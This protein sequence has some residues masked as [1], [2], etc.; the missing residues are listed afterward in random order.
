VFI[1]AF[2]SI[3]TIFGTKY[4]ILSQRFNLCVFR[5]LSEFQCAFV[6][7][8]E[9]DCMKREELLGCDKQHG[10]KNKT[11][12]LY[13]IDIQMLYTEVLQLNWRKSNKTTVI[14]CVKISKWIRVLHASL[15]SFCK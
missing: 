5:D 7:G 6:R 13:L 15:N 1:V 10:V 2:Y 4:D 3:F 11:E 9:D 12:Y 14:V 8:L